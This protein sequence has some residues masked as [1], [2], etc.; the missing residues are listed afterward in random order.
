MRTLGRLAVFPLS[1]LIA[2][3]L[4]IAAAPAQNPPRVPGIPGI[5]GIGR[6]AVAAPAMQFG[7]SRDQVET[8]VVVAQM[9]LASPECS[10]TATT[11]F[12]RPSRY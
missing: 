1:L 4:A 3:T 2:A 9:N 12:N 5:P 6:P 11:T 10:L 7:D 8:G